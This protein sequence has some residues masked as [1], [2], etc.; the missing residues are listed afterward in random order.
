MISSKNIFIKKFFGARVVNENAYGM[1]KGRW[2][3]LFKCTECRLI[4]VRSSALS[5]STYDA[6]KDT[7]ESNLNRMKI[8]FGWPLE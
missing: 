3:I 1:L 2:R 7:L 4:N 6:Q 8:G 5:G